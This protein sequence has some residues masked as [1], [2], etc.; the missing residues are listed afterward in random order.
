VPGTANANREDNLDRL[1]AQYLSFCPSAN[2]TQIADGRQRFVDA[3]CATCHMGPMLD[4][5]DVQSTGIVN[6]PSNADVG[7]PLGCVGVE[8]ALPD[9]NQ[10]CQTCGDQC[11]GCDGLGCGSIGIM[12]FDVRP[13]IDVAR[14]KKGVAN[15][16]L[17]TF[18]HDASIRTLHD[19][20]AFYQT[21]ESRVPINPSTPEQINDMVAFLSAL[22]E[23]GD[24]SVCPPPLPACGD[25][26]RIRARCTDNGGLSAL[27]V[28][29]NES[30]DGQRVTFGINGVPF[31]GG[32]VGRLAKLDHCCQ[33]GTIEVS[34]LEPAGCVT[35]VTLQCIV[36]V[37]GTCCQPSGACGTNTQSVCE[38]NN[39][40]FLGPGV[41]CDPNPCPQPATGACCIPDGTC[42]ISTQANCSGIYSGDDTVCVPDPCPEPTGACCFMDGTCA[43]QTEALCLGAGGAY[44]GNGTSCTPNLCPQPLGACCAHSGACS[45]I[46]EAECLAAGSIFQ[47]D[48]S[49]CVPDLCPLP[50]GACC[51]SDETCSVDTQPACLAALGTYR[52]DDTECNPSPCPTVPPVACSD[53]RR[54]RARCNGDGSTSALIVLNNT[55]HDG[56]T[57]TFS[58]DGVLIDAVVSGRLAPLTE[59]C[60]TGTFDVDLAVPAGCV[61]PITITC[62]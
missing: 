8:C 40:I 35:P 61:T 13:L 57:V 30:H 56:Q 3:L 58:I 41:A 2:A 59:C 24:P 55:L 5:I 11:P 19:A 36:E 1:I 10:L 54:I 21:P 37:P 33:T 14:V 34:L 29:N 16:N 23:V 26:R 43:E 42:V 52:G 38:L 47:G 39:G 31:D 50:V 15:E 62:P 27:A 45:E 46:T 12:E 20:V 44:S 17:G 51:F 6:H 48:F 7:C 18:F 49:A 28:L 53:V 32:I 60:P 4:D 25:V 9:E 22:V